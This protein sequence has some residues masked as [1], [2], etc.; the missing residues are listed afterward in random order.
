MIGLDQR[1]KG[2][3]E[4]RQT[5]KHFNL[6]T[7]GQVQQPHG[8]CSMYFCIN[9]IKCRFFFN[10]V[11]GKASPGKYNYFSCFNTGMSEYSTFANLILS[12]C[13]ILPI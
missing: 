11:K 3:G 5:L 13:C 8:S 7:S 10:V 2:D 12:I 4:S 9:I 1:G 6:V